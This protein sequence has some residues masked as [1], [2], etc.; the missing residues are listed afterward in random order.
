VAKGLHIT[1]WS[2]QDRAWQAMAE[3]IVPEISAATVRRILHDVALQPHRTRYWKTA[4]WD[5]GFK[6]RAEQV[7]GCYSNALRL[8]EQGRWVVCVDEIPN[9]QVL[10]RCPIRRA[11]PGSIEQQEFEYTRHG[12]VNI[13]VFLVVHTGPMEAMIVEKKESLSIFLCKCLSS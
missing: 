6:Q 9:C 3:G 7:L 12:T 2:N 8:A 11:I 10:E 5:A 4:R 1:H 13:W